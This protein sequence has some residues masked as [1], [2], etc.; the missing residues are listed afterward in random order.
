MPE[1]EGSGVTSGLLPGTSG[2]EPQAACEDPRR[3]HHA[4]AG[5]D[6]P[7]EPQDGG[8]W[9]AWPGS[10]EPGVPA[11]ASSVQ[12]LVSMSVS[13]LSASLRVRP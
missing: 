1:P 7:S 6:H 5:E 4:V 13:F 12:F 2:V 8:P 10:W 3:Q 11:S 9:P